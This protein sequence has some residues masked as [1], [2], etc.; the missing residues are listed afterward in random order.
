M[1]PFL[2]NLGHAVCER[3]D[4]L[5]RPA[6]LQVGSRPIAS[7]AAGSGWRN[8]GVVVAERRCRRENDGT[9]DLWP[10]NCIRVAAVGLD[11][12]NENNV[13][14]GM[15]AVRPTGSQTS[16][17]LDVSLLLLLVSVG[18]AS[19][20]PRRDVNNII[21]PTDVHTENR[22]AANLSAAVADEISSLKP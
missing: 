16:T 12:V 8:G 13:L 20:G 10:P 21:R 15:L 7:T 9:A 6:R 14:S 22:Y 18:V 1:T 17:A 11:V 3:I 5:I 2:T 4:E 19:P